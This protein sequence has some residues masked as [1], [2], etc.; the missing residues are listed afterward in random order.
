MVFFKLKSKIFSFISIFLIILI[1][2]YLS[3]YFSGKKAEQDIKNNLQY[4][5]EVSNAAINHI[6]TRSLFFTKDDLTKDSYI[7]LSDHL[8][9][10][11][12]ASKN[13]GVRW[14]Y[15]MKVKNG[16]IVFGPDSVLP[17]D[18]GHS[19][20]G[21]IYT[22]ASQEELQSVL[23]V[24]ET[25]E[26]STVG[27]YSDR[28]GTWISINVPVKDEN[29][30]NTGVVLGVD[31]DY[32]YFQSQ[33]LSKQILP[34]SIFLSLIVLFSITG[35]YLFVVDKKNRQIQ[36]NELRF[37]NFYDKNSDAIMTLEPPF[38]NFTSGNPASI[39]LFAIN[40][41]KEFISLSPG[42]LSP[43]KQPD[44]SLS[45]DLAKLMIQKAMERGSNLFEWVHKKYKGES[46][47]AIVLLSKVEVK[48]KEFLL[49]TVRDVSVQKKQEQELKRKTKELEEL[50]S[51]MVGREL[52]MIELKKEIEKLKTN[53]NKI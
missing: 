51:F 24:I 50:N 16:D 26:S 35:M 48:D 45:S 9:R 14:I 6:D 34:A 8:Q 19:Q 18:Y 30:I 37:R 22:E 41:E 33:V 5:G 7:A 10:I 38:W 3:V 49:A 42:D 39:K 28:W 47:P 13:F 12:Q 1:S 32:K 20:P 15:L 27:P 52:K 44:G 2:G 40:N 36:E 11:A 4:Y 31:I 23:K 29:N 25:G 17:Q 43:E 46:F 21:D 53:E